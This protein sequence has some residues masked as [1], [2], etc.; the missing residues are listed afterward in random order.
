MN[1]DNRT[2]AQSLAVQSQI[3]LPGTIGRLLQ[4]IRD[5]EHIAPKFKD[6]GLIKT[7]ERPQTIDL[8]VSGIATRSRVLKALGGFLF[9]TAAVRTDLLIEHNL[10]STRGQDSLCE[11][12]DI[13]FDNQHK[14]LALIEIQQAYALVERTLG[15]GDPIQLLLIDTPLFL[16]REMAPMAADKAYGEAFEKATSAIAGF[17]DRHRERIFPWN[18]DGPM[19]CGVLAERY[20]AITYVARQDI[21]TAEGRKHVLS[22]DGIN[23]DAAAGLEEISQRVAGIGE[24]RFLSGVLSSFTRTAA[25]RITERQSR[26]E[27]AA[28]VEQGLIGFHYK[29]D[30]L[31]GIRLAQMAGDEPLWKRE[32]LDRLSGHLMNLSCIGGTRVAPL[33]IQLSTRELSQLDQFVQFYRAGLNEGLRNRQVED[34]WLSDLDE[35]LK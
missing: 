17:W 3:R 33:P 31:S 28:G 8:E 12:D 19:L 2:L 20:G 34:A 30:Q 1:P 9:G 7:V 22:S 26:M 29:A 10:L 5:I 6:V 15:S 27:P 16:N 35:E 32:H 13:A 21:R 25:F 18:P 23:P 11:L 14:Y 24:Q 4:Q